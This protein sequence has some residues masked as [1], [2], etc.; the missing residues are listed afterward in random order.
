MPRVASHYP[1]INGGFGAK[2]ALHFQSSNYRF[3]PKADI[4]SMEVGDALWPI[5]E[6]YRRFSG[7]LTDPA[8]SN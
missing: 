8:K 7:R 5:S 1:N 3:V 6:T 2:A 4:R